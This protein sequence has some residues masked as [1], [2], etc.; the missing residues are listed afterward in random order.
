MPRRTNIFQ[1]VVAIIHEHMAAAA[2][3]QESAMLV[4]RATGFEREVD[5]VIRSQVAGYELIVS[6]EATARRRKVD[7]QWVEG[8]VG[9]HADLPTSLLVL[10]SEAGF[11]EAARQLAAKKG[12]VALAPEDLH[13]QHP[14]YAV[15]KALPSLW[16]KQVTITAQQAQLLVQAPSG[17]TPM[18][19]DVPVTAMLFLDDRTIVGTLRDVFASWSQAGGWSSLVEHMSAFSEDTDQSFMIRFDGLAIREDDHEKPLYLGR[20]TNDELDLIDK[21]QITGLTTIRVGEIPL[22][23]QRLGDVSFAYGEGKL[24]SRPALAV[25]TRGKITLR[26]RA[27]AEAPA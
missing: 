22:R 8:M 2:T 24:G 4:S 20:E 23:R 1:E 9:K 13:V 26:V 16:P 12:A 21:G 6:V 15:L 19:R 25:V 17:K 14:D 5:V 27:D 18:V 10:V 3:V 7:V 11:T